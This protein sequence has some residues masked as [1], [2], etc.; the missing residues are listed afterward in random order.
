V[1]LVTAV[2]ARSGRQPGE[3]AL[4]LYGSAGPPPAPGAGPGIAADAPGTP[5]DDAELVRL[6]DEIDRLEA[7]VRAR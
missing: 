3:I 4:L 1:G 2:A 7:E 6:A 5:A